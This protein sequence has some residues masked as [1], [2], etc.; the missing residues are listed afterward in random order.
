MF[1]RTRVYVMLVPEKRVVI[2]DV[3][4]ALVRRFVSGNV[5]TGYFGLPRLRTGEGDQEG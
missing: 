5:R 3:V 1:R 4:V 2:F